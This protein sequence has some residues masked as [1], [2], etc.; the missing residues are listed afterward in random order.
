MTI[1]CACLQTGV[2]NPNVMTACVVELH[3]V[4]VSNYPFFYSV[5]I[6]SSNRFRSMNRFLMRGPIAACLVHL[7]G[8]RGGEVGVNICRL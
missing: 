1:V 8:G 3:R 4:F 5:K 2:L 7:D 6:A